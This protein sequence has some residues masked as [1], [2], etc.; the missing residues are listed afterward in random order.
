MRKVIQRQSTIVGRL[1]REISRNMTPLSQ[2]VQEALGVSPRAFPGNPYGGHT[3]NAAG[4]NIRW[5]LRMIVKKGVGL[6]FA[7]YRP[8][9]WGI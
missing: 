8:A 6:F 4:S 9:V 2:A 5:L 3:L 1:H 7:C